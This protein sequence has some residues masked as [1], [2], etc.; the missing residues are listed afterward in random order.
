MTQID[1]E[2]RLLEFI[3]T[4]GIEFPTYADSNDVSSSI[5]VVRMP[6]SR[7]I[8]EDFE[9][10]KDKAFNYFIQIKCDQTERQTAVSAIETL[11]DELDD[12]LDIESRNG[13]YE[14]LGTAISSEPYFMGESTDGS[15]FFRLM[16]NTNL[17]IK[18][19]IK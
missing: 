11:A 15:L 12:V 4:L 18:G 7:T 10:N 8:T 17:S 19:D 14:Y 13:S 16:F 6:G 5:S 3:D 1:F 2:D 9:G